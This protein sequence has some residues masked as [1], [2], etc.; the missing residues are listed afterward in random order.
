M[1]VGRGSGNEFPGHSRRGHSDH[2]QAHEAWRARHAYYCPGRDEAPIARPDPDRSRPLVGH[3]PLAHPKEDTSPGREDAAECR[4]ANAQLGARFRCVAQS[5][6]ESPAHREDELTDGVD[7][8]RRKIDGPRSHEPSDR[9]PQVTAL[10]NV[11]HVGR[12]NLDK[13]G[14]RRDPAGLV[15]VTDDHEAPG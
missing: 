8:P 12:C 7:P 5:L 4:E 1:A 9:R 14:D 15:E 13:S 11:E 10:E 6:L 3:H 2:R